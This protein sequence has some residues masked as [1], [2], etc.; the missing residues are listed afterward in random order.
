MST[1]P[2][3]AAE[4]KLP[5]VGEG[6]TE[7]D[8]ASWKVAVGDT[9]TV[10]Q[11]LV[12]IETAKALVELPSPQAGVIE[13][14]LAEAGQTVQVGTPIV[15]F[16]GEGANDDAAPPQEDGT[17]AETPAQE[18]QGEEK[19]GNT[20]VGYGASAERRRARRRRG[21]E[22]QPPRQTPSEPDSS[23]G[24]AG[25]AD[26]DRP[27]AETG[28]RSG[29]AL[30]SPPVRKLAKDLGI[31]LREVPPTG[32]RGNV[33]RQDLLDYHQRRQPAQQ[34]PATAQP[35]SSAQTSQTKEETRIPVA[36]VRKATA[37]AMVSSA[38]TA[39]H[40]TVFLDVDVT[41]SL[42]FL[43]ELK[44]EPVLAHVK[45]TPMLLLARAVC[46]AVGRNPMVNGRFTEEQI[47]L[48][49]EVN[50]GIAAATERGLIVP[51][52]KS[53]QQMSLVQLAE[54]L[55]ALTERAREGKTTPAEMKDGTLTI[56]NVGVFGVDSGTPILNPGESAIV[57]FGRIRRIP[58]EHQDQIALRQV[59][60]LAVS[61]DHRILDGKEMALFLSDIGRALADPKVML[62]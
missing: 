10:N 5:D 7:A 56:T 39:P 1:A 4:F 31:D 34:V 24:P 22:P 19:T 60:T 25:R 59:T 3:E 12:E 13:A 18:Q 11:V 17:S 36:G 50:L 6:L 49:P 30:A 32:L 46:W 16:A 48:S 43:A 45:I 53:A 21:R 47:I 14:L 29:P 52:I 58:W 61:A 38:F 37:A 28:A 55:A 44:Q 54:A 9:V 2:T 23:P 35:T 15:R 57:A 51:N 26:H 33:T 41:E 62:L 20:L 27:G 40:V 8:I 42:E